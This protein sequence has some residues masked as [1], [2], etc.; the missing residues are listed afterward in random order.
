M[1]VFTAC[2]G[3][4]ISCSVWAANIPHPTPGNGGQGAD[5]MM[6]NSP[7]STYTAGAVGYVLIVMVLV[8]TLVAGG[9]L[10]VNIALMSERSQD[11]GKGDFEASDVGILK[12][13]RLGAGNVRR[14]LPPE[15]DQEQEMVP[16]HKHPFDEKSILREEEMREDWAPRR[17]S[18]PKRPAA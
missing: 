1:R 13:E 12:G 6:A 3:F 5:A 8:I 7:F 14:T 9:I 2:L 10:V 18:K 17:R 16:A 15:E 4:L 11:K